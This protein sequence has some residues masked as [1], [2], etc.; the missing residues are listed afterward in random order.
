MGLQ[1]GITSI[2]KRGR[3]VIPKE[4]REKLGLKPEQRIVL[5]LRGDELVLKP[6]LSVEDFIAELKGCIH[7]SRIKPEELKRIWGVKG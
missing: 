1:M 3:V 2:D 7:G 4:L 6:A 5:E